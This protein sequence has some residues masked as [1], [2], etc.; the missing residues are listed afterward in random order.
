[1]GQIKEETISRKSR[2]G[3]IVFGVI[4]VLFVVLT[5]WESKDLVGS[6]QALVIWVVALSFYFLPII[7]AAK[8]KHPQILP[9]AVI[10]ILLGWTIIGWIV[11][12]V[13]SV[14]S[15]KVSKD[16]TTAE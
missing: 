4:A 12:L 3:L 2:E 6:L 7:I 8:W 13:W 5:A 10:N 1:M 9:I 11:A 14:S 15:S 16:S